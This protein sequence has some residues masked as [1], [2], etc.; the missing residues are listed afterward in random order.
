MA[1][2]SFVSSWSFTYDIAFELVFAVVSLILALFAF[3]LYR[4]TDENKSKLFGISF[5]LISISYMVQFISNLLVI[6]KLNEQICAAAGLSSVNSVSYFGAYIHF[7][8]MLTGFA[9][10]LYMTFNI[11]HPEVLLFLLI[12]SIVTL[13]M[14]G[15][16]FST[17]Y[18][19]STLFLS[20]IT[21]HF[22]KNYVRNRQKLTLL[23]ALAFSFFLFGVV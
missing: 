11:K 20:F 17:F 9:V 21:W 5:L 18:L 6:T 14:S 12:L 10:L 13:V 7:L 22:V 3:K 16:E 19:L 15:N 2:D 8:L 4:I 1:L 23:V